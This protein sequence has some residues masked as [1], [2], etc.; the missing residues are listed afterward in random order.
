MQR[1]HI[2]DIPPRAAK[3]YHMPGRHPQPPDFP[4]TQPSMH[5]SHHRFLVSFAVGMLCIVAMGVLWIMVISPWYQGIAN[6]WQYGDARVAIR[7]ANVGHGGVSRFYACM[8]NGQVVVVEVM[9]NTTAHVFISPSVFGSPQDN[10]IVTIT[11][12]DVNH[13]G[14]PDLV[15]HIQ[16]MEI[17]P[18][19]FNTGTS[20][21]WTSP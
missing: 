18:V 9:T 5:P 13:D 12:E 10:R 2:T 3:Y 15:L 20:F 7:T 8:V 16:G 6:Q 14:K 1:P 11:M 4:V 19:L 17:T 21:Q